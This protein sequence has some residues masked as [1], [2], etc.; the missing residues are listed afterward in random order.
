LS[1]Y[2]GDAYKP[3]AESE[4]T[5]DKQEEGSECAIEFLDTMGTRHSTPQSAVLR[6]LGAKLYLHAHRDH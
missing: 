1:A 4:D 2:I 5:E 6:Q 3:L